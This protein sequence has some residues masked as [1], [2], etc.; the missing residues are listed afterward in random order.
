VWIEETNELSETDLMQVDLRLRGETATY[1][2]IICT[3][4][5]VSALHWLKSRFV[6]QPQDNVFALKTTYL[7]NRFIDAEYKAVLDALKD[8]NPEYYSVYCLGEWGDLTGLI[9]RDII[10][11]ECS[12][13]P[14]DYNVFTNGIDF[15]FV[16]PSVLIRVGIR[17]EEIYI[18]TELYRPG[19]TNAQFIQE[20][21]RIVPAGERG[22]QDFWCD[23]AEPDRVKEFHQAGYRSY[24]VAKGP[25]SVGTGI[26]W[27]LRRRLHISPR[28]PNTIKEIRA[29]CRRKD[30]YGNTNKDEPEAVNDHA[31][32]ALRYAIERY[33]KVHGKPGIIGGAA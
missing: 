26:D 2:Q 8:R 32:D 31:M 3:F 18:P 27:L 10:V 28:W 20:C 25:G 5:P 6:D 15:G 4:N 19:L 21:N 33:R 14:E 12:P 24:P 11:E 1:K 7:D 13:R 17:D 22:T 23:C 16:N 9:F 29:Y 30:K